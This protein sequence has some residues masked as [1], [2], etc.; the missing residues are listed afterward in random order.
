MLTIGGDVLAKEADRMELGLF[1]DVGMS[2]P[3]WTDAPSA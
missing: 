1:G 3:E 2:R